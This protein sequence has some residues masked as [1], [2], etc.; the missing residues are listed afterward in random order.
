MRPPGRLVWFPGLG[1][2]RVAVQ[3]AGVGVAT[4]TANNAATGGPRDVRL[5]AASSGHGLGGQA[6]QQQPPLGHWA[7]SRNVGR[8]GGQNRRRQ[9]RSS[10][11]TQ[12]CTAAA[13]IS[14]RFARARVPVPS[15]RRPPARVVVVALHPGRR[16]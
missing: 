11:S 2:C 16:G 14:W 3:A 4:A 7:A 1:L 5:E 8:D 15:A 10:S 13:A 9:A 12:A 6:M